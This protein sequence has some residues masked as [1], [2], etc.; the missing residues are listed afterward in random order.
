MPTSLGMRHNATKPSE[1]FEN[2]GGTHVNAIGHSTF[3]KIVQD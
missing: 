1:I 3:I 2:F